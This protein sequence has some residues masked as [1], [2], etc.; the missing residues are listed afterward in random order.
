MNQSTVYIIPKDP[1]TSSTIFLTGIPVELK[2]YITSDEWFGIIDG[3]NKIML[4]YEKPS[5][6]NF[7]RIL[8]V[9]PA[10]F[11][12]YSYDNAVRE[13]L[14]S[15]NQRLVEKGFF[16]DDPSASSYMELKLIFTIPSNSF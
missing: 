8:L 6:L 9:I 13:Y 10:L 5:L 1:R 15:T 12:F 14:T 16:I 11:D 2:D 4:S 3:L 7:F